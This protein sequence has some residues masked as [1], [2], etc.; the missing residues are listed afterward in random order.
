MIIRLAIPQA[1]TLFLLLDFIIRLAF[2]EGA[3]QTYVDR[4]M[5]VFPGD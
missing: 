5:L 1:P 3:I 4:I 2:S